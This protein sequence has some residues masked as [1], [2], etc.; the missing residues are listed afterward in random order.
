MPNLN[1][2]INKIAALTEILN[3][4]VPGLIDCT[5]KFNLNI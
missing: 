2:E 1:S 4:M 3:K 5:S